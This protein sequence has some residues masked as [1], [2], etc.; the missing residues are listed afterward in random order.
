MGNELLKF[1][2]NAKSVKISNIS[3]T[4]LLKVPKF[5]E[6]IKNKIEEGAKFEILL[7]KRKRKGNDISYLRIREDDEDNRQLIPKL[8]EMLFEL[9]CFY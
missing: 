3:F 2:K 6:M 8:N 5:K 1:I 4:I 7:V 9:F